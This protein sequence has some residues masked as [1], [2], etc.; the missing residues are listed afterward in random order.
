M[1]KK[2][3]K[4]ENKKQKAKSKK[5]KESSV[6]LNKIKI[7]PLTIVLFNSNFY[8]RF[9]FDCNKFTFLIFERTSNQTKKKKAQTTE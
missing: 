2:G 6:F 5:Q 8:F 9:V 7:K 3:R 1:N 4:E